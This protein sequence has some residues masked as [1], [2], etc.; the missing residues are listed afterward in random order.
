MRKTIKY[1]SACLNYLVW[2]F[3]SRYKFEKLDYKNMKKVLIVNTGVIGDLLA[4]TPLIEKLS[5]S[6]MKVDILINP[7][8]KPIF[9]N[10]KNINNILTLN[11][12]RGFINSLKNQN[13]DLA[14]L[15]YPNTKEV[16]K[17]LLDS[18]IPY[19]IADVPYNIFGFHSI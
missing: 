5:E 3:F 10:N 14:I 16:A 19:R 7:E 18:K 1:I 4:T 2:L 12:S 11:Q 17:L 15:I 13:Y 9:K 8:M 6:N